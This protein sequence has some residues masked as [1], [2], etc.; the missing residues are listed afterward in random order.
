MVLLL[1]IFLVGGRKTWKILLDKQACAPHNITPDRVRTQLTQN[2]G[3]RTLAGFLYESD[4]RFFV[5]TASE[6]T[7]V[8]D[9]E[10]IVMAPG[11]IQLKDV[12]KVSFGVEE[13]TTISRVNGKDAISM[14]A[15]KASQVN[16]IE[17]SERCL[18]LIEQLNEK[19]RAKDVEI[20]VQRNLA[21]SMEQNIQQIINL[22]LIGGLLAVFVL[23]IFLKDIRLI[24]VI[25]V[26]IPLS[27]FTA[28]NLFY[29]AGISINSLTLVGMALAIGML[30]DNSIVVLENI[31]RLVSSG[32]ST[33]KAVTQGVSGVAKAIIAA[34][35]TT[36]TVFLPFL[37][38]GNY[39]VKLIGMHIGVSIISTLM[40]SLLVAIL[41]IPV[42]GSLVLG[43]YSDRRKASFGR[44]KVKARAERLYLVL[45]KSSLRYPARIIIGALLLFFITAF[46]VLALSVSGLEEVESDQIDVFVTMAKGSTLENTDRVVQEIETKIEEV[47]E[48]Q[49]V[50]SRIQEE[51][52]VVSVKLKEDFE[53]IN[54]RTFNE[55]KAQVE[56][57]TDKIGGARISLSQEGA[58]QESQSMGGMGELG[59]LLGFGSNRERVVV[60]GE[61]YELLQRVAQ[62]LL[63]YIQ[64]LED[65]RSA[66]LNT[67]GSRPEVTLRFDP[68]TLS[69]NDIAPR[70]IALALRDF[71]QEPP[72]DTRFQYVEEEYNIIIRERDRQEPELKPKTMDDLRD[73]EVADQRGGMHKMASFSNIQTGSGIDEIRRINQQKQIEISYALSEQASQ[74]NALIDAHKESI[75]NLI[76]NYPAPP[77]IAIEIEEAE[78]QIQE[79]KPLAGAAIPAY[80]H[81]LSFGIR[82]SFSSLCPLILYSF[83]CDWCTIRF[84][85]HR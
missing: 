65:T 29:G 54:N 84:G 40:V 30:L 9:I 3:S 19:L 27:A 74:S 4:R 63:Y 14:T 2:S 67:R 45:L 50:S 61:D 70:N 6:Y 1:L 75:Q 58:G 53:E 15:T 23:W 71:G 83:S 10:N 41:L 22:A 62:D 36:A 13:E 80:L 25:A 51:D 32:L 39:L 49:D 43:L 56:N 48:K 11:P 76:N 44:S 18:G 37:F 77:G 34:T 26:A 46:T 21:D 72:A 59:Q 60:K 79:F 68:L 52:A 12:A 35:L 73:L 42:L 69:R 7:D 57:L 81:D 8:K 33:E 16:I 64:N 78:N 38:F 20:V 55:I 28:F 82:I 17:L 31:F 66:N 85:H 5:R 47:A 24:S